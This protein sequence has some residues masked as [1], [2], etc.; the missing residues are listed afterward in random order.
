MEKSTLYN[1]KSQNNKYY[2]K[3]N[4]D[5]EHLSIIKYSHLV[6]I[7]HLIMMIEYDHIHTAPNNLD[8]FLS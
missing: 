2:R 4:E 6:H 5:I 8:D 7:V 1:K 3:S